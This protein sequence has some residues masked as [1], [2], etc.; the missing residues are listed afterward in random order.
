MPLQIKDFDDLAVYAN[1]VMERSAHHAQGVGGAALAL[2]G[3]ILWRA[4]TAS[5][6]AFG[7]AGGRGNV[8][9]VEISGNRYA[10][11][12]DH[13]LAEIV[14]K[15]GNTRGPVLH[16]F[17]NSTSTSSIEALFRTL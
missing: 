5:L 4:D 6:E 8:L 2:M 16:R 13:D 12:Y 17:D 3:A 10:F 11:S 9:W 7:N 14:M 15:Q 1:G